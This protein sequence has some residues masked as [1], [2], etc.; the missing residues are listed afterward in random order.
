VYVAHTKRSLGL[1]LVGLLV[2]INWESLFSIVLLRENL[3]ADVSDRTTHPYDGNFGVWQYVVGGTIALVGLVALE[4][5]ALALFS[6]VS[7]IPSSARSMMVLQAGTMV[8]F[9]GL[10]TRIVGNLQ[11]VAIDLSHKLINTDIVN[12][13]VI[14]LILACL[15][16]RYLVIKHY[17]YLM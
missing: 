10:A 14:P 3:F 17:F 9:L 16:L 1:V 8:T 12:S 6:K 13:L 15:V 7:P 4:G 2:A 5:A 11:I